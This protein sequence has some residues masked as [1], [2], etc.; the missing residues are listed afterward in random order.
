MLVVLEK[1]TLGPLG[2][3]IHAVV[4]QRVPK[5]PVVQIAAGIHVKMMKRGGDVGLRRAPPL[6]TTTCT[7]R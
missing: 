1:Q 4:P 3:H 2:V 6:T 7:L 5:L